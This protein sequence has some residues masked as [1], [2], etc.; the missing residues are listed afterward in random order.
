MKIPSHDGDRFALF[1]KLI[2]QCFASRNNRIALYNRWRMFYLYGTDNGNSDE[3][4]NKIYP[5]L[6][7]INSF[8]YSNETTRFSIQIGAEVSQNNMK[9]IPKLNAAVNDNWHSS[10]GDIVYSNALEW[11]HV[12]ASTFV[13]LRWNGRAI[14]PFVCYPHDFGV[15]REDISQLSRQEAFCQ[16]YLASRSQV[17]YDLRRAKHPNL[18]QLLAALTPANDMG[19][20]TGDSMGRVI[21]SQSIPSTGGD[22]VQGSFNGMIDQTSQYIPVM[23]TDLLQM[24]E[25]YVFDDDLQDFRVI[26][27]GSPAFVIYDRPLDR[28]Y[29][30]NEIPFNQVCPI[31]DPGYF[32]GRSDVERLIPLQMMRNERFRQVRKMMALQAEPPSSLT[33]FPGA[34]DEVKAALNSPGG[35]V[36]TDI[37][38]AKAEKLSPII[39][40]DLFA[41]I[42]SIDRQ[43]EEVTGVNN[44]MSGLGETGVRSANHAAQ[45][46]TLGASRTKKRALIIEDSLEKLATSYLQILQK[47]DVT[48][49]ANTS[50]DLFT[51]AQF[52]DEFTVKVDAHSNSP[53]FTSDTAQKAIQLFQLGAITKEKLIEMIGVPMEQ[54]LKQDLKNIIEPADARAAAIGAAS[55]KS[56]KV[57]SIK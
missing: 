28:M 41:D 21:T 4:Y 31:P 39:P 11:A 55:G 16:A 12:Y 34:T 53:I 17:E 7:Q 1:D 54:L 47:F 44:V 57:Q 56:P 19:D 24:Q 45:L 35:V 27:L 3:T 49:Y 32:W 33:G 51:A 2:Q 15:L 48:R 25:L 30:K 22:V 50:G 26:T 43:F 38:G 37:P 29:V 23:P 36:Y 13:K 14:E 40:D 8:M 46:A 20:Q 6:D 42:A 18:P 9:M 10:N 52:S 5:H